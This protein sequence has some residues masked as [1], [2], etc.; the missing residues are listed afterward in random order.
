[1]PFAASGRIIERVDTGGRVGM[2]WLLR[3]GAAPLVGLVLTTA[4]CG[5]S[6]GGPEHPAVGQ[7]FDEHGRPLSVGSDSRLEVFRGQEHCE[8]TS[9]I[10]MLVSLPDSVVPGVVDAIYTRDPEGVLPGKSAVDFSDQVALPADAVYTGYHR[11]G[12]ELWVLPSTV[13]QEVYVVY[14][15]RVERWPRPTGFGLCA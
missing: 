11:G 4:A 13:A 5:A 1:L 6:N 9:A 3:L 7:W 14:G 2:S 8:W 10:I 15:E 12:V